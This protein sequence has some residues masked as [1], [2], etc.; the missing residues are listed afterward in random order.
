MIKLQIRHSL[1]PMQ[2]DW[3]KESIQFT[4]FLSQLGVH[5]DLFVLTHHQNG[6]VERKHN[7]LL[8]QASQ[9]SLSLLYQDYTLLISVYLI[10]RFSIAPLNFKV[11]HFILFNKSTDYIFLKVFGCVCFHILILCKNHTQY[12][13]SHECLILRHSPSHK[14]IDS[15]LQ[16]VELT[17]IRMSYSMSTG[18]YILTSFPKLIPSHL[19]TDQVSLSHLF[20]LYLL[21]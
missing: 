18:F 19:E 17:S 15:F 13:R 9:T 12:F 16:L 6:L 8:N 5:I 14:A 3:R 11:P 4:K 2:I 21:S 10:N 7:T 1:K 20:L